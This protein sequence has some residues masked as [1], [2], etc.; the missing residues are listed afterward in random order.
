MSDAAVT[1]TTHSPT[2]SR[3]SAPVPESTVHT[4][5][6]VAEYARVVCALVGAV[7]VGA[8]S[9]KVTVSVL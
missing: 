1:V 5:E 3:V 7:T 4:V 6:G 9:P 8:V 2:P